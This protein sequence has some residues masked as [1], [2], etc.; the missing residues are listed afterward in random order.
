MSKLIAALLICMALAGCV[1]PTTRTANAT[2]EQVDQEAVYQRELVVQRDTENRRRLDTVWT[3]IRISSAELCETKTAVL[4]LYPLESKANDTA[5]IVQ[6]LYRLPAGLSAYLVPP[7][8]PAAA[9]GLEQGDEIRAI[10]GQAVA[11]MKEVSEA[12][13]ELEAGKAV[14]LS[15]SRNGQEK[16]LDVLPVAAC[17][18]GMEVSN[19]T[20]VN[21]YADGKKLVI[22]RGMLEFVK[23]DEELALVVSHELAHNM[24]KHMDAKKTNAMGGLL[25]DLAMMV[26]TRGLYRNTHI[27]NAAGGAYSQ[28]FESE[29]DYVGLYLMAR[30]G[31]RIDE[32]PKFWRRMAVANPANIK[33]NHSASHPSTAQRMVALDNA[34]AE[35]NQ[36]KNAGQALM[37]N[38]KEKTASK[39]EK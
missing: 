13:K 35:I 18:Y 22:T 32:A 21:A 23:S 4:G 16:T 11:S 31:Y 6:K 7:G 36:K 33:S 9:A 3:R 25:A 30:A 10:N 2:K 37:P 17:G 26:A 27:A 39:D 20:E 38:L 15:L 14:Q 28:E 24:M 1:A 19:G 29:A 34:V 12:T 5:A 8:S